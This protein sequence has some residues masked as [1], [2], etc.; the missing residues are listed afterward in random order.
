MLITEMGIKSSKF[1]EILAINPA[2]IS[3]I[4]GGRNK[5][6]FDLLQ[7][8]LIAFPAVS[9]EWLMLGTGPMCRAGYNYPTQGSPADGATGSR[10]PVTTATDAT[11]SSD[12]H[13]FASP[14]AHS[15]FD[16]ALP[17]APTGD[18]AATPDRSA[19]AVG[20]H[21]ETGE[22]LRATTSAGG[23]RRIERIVL[24]YSDQTFESF[25]PTKR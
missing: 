1:A 24:F 9:P 4:L 10:G 7:K 21:A 2:G 11:D 19:N 22:Q 12:Q 13:G 25:S 16:E 6:G 14:A 20:L 8:I 3:H 23:A 18:S 15:L 5:P 17:F